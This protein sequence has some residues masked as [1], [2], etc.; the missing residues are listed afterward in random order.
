[1]EGELFP[2][3]SGSPVFDETGALVA[4]IVMREVSG[5]SSSVALALPLMNVQNWIAGVR[6][7]VA[8]ANVRKSENFKEVTGLCIFLGKQS[9][10]ARRNLNYPDAPFGRGLLRDVRQKAVGNS[11]QPSFE[12]TDS[13]IRIAPQTGAINLRSRCPEVRDGR[14]FYSSIVAQLDGKTQ[15]KIGPVQPLRYLDDIFYWATVTQIIR[16]R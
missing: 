7:V 1:L 5:G 6:A 9:A 8:S 14:V 11:S 4:I 12:F 3:E 2:S 13:P 10:L 15:I 16:D